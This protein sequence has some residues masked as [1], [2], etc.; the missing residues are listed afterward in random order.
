MSF[1]DAL[2]DLRECFV[3]GSDDRL[4][5]IEQLLDLLEADPADERTLRD[6]MIQFHGFSGAG[7]T[8][9]FPGVSALGNEGERHCDALLKEKVQPEARQIQRWRSLLE[10]LRR[11]LRGEPALGGR[12]TRQLPL[13]FARP[14]TF[15]SSI[16][17]PRSA[18]P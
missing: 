11:E 7:S 9:G 3:R 10:S 17:T 15:S 4:A 13:R 1:E 14:S 2:R 8:Y 5:R 12:R 16:R 18:T 6:V